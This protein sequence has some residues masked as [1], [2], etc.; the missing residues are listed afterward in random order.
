MSDSPVNHPE[1][2]I[3]L[4][5]RHLLSLVLRVTD[6]SASSPQAQ[7][8]ILVPGVHLL[9]HDK[10]FFLTAGHILQQID[11]A[12]TRDLFSIDKAMIAD[13]FSADRITN[14]PI[15]FEFSRQSC[16]YVVDDSRGLDIGLIEL[17]DYYIRLM[18]ANGILPI[19]EVNW[20]RQHTIS[21]EYYFVLG[22]PTQFNPG[23]QVPP[24]Q[25]SLSPVLVPAYPL[26]AAQDDDQCTDEATF[27]AQLPNDCTVD[28][29]GMS[30]GPIFGIRTKPKVEYWIVAIQRS[31]LP[32]RKVI[33]GSRVPTIGWLVTWAVEQMEKYQGPRQ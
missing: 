27:C 18:K 7:R 10:N 32:I 9:A 4:F 19:T 2:L 15:P 13:V 25:A 31:W 22:F 12:L 6:K 20:A 5:G 8:Q 29:D 14:Y 30:G 17:T 1:I 26:D 23:D 3:D 16:H 28:F 24:G 21:F 33:I 11:R